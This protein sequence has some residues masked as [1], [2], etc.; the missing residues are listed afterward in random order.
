M[1]YYF[2]CP[3]CDGY[4]VINQ[5]E[6]NCFIFRHAVYKLNM[7]SI[8]PHASLSECEHLINNNLVYGCSKPLQYDKTNNKLVKCDYI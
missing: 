3:H 4:I 8:N 5:N 2:N 7:Q 6:F 1:D